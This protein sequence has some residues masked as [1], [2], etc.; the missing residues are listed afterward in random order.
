MKKLLQKF[1]EKLAKS[2]S[3]AF[4]GQPLDCCSLN[5]KTTVNTKKS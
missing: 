5:K 4:N 1:I 3:E 2:N